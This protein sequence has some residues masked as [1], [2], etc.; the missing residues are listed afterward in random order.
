MSSH[1]TQ[2]R[3]GEYGFGPPYTVTEIACFDSTGAEKWRYSGRGGKMRGVMAP[4]GEGACFLGGGTDAAGEDS[5]VCVDSSGRQSWSSRVV[6]AEGERL[7]HIDIS[8]RG[9]VIVRSTEGVTYGGRI[10][11]FD[12][13]T[14]RELWQSKLELRDDAALSF[15]PD[16]ALLCWG[17]M[18]DEVG[19]GESV[20]V[21]DPRSGAA[22]WSAL[23]AWEPS[24]EPLC[25]PDGRIYFVS[26]H[27]LNCLDTEGRTLW[28]N[29]G[30]G[31]IWSDLHFGPQGLVY[32]KSQ[33]RLHCL[34]PDGSEAW[35]LPAGDNGGA[36]AVDGDGVFYCGEG[37]ELVAFKP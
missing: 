22:R 20:Y 36:F 18:P 1:K 11:A 10:I 8:P 6:L 25:G 29:P 27:A 32:V 31:Y 14:G 23:L 15:L 33:G 37:E 35:R 12:G 26:S 7:R 17:R 21:L 5:L 34:R 19:A 9:S 30:E 28:Q 13:A 3:E 2:D 24:Q 16:G 4:L